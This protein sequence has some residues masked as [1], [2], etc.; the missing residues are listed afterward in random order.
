MASGQLPSLIV[1]GAWQGSGARTINN[2]LSLAK[3]RQR[4]RA[5]GAVDFFD[6]FIKT[7]G[8]MRGT[9]GFEK[10][11]MDY[12]TG[13]SARCPYVASAGALAMRFHQCRIFRH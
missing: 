2:L 3:V 12:R 10:Q 9:L 11:S 7:A 8:G 4:I 13:A 1:I 5:R 6:I